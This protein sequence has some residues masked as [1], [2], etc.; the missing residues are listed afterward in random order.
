MTMHNDHPV[1]WFTFGSVVGLVK[2][3]WNGG[4]RFEFIQAQASVRIDWLA[5]YSHMM[6]AVIIAVFAGAATYLG[7]EIMRWIVRKVRLKFSNSKNKKQ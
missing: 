6:E 5:V 7:K 2:Y 1:A 3:Y 4:F